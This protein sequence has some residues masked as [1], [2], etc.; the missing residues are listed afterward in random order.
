MTKE[1]IIKN[2]TEEADYFERLANGLYYKTEHNPKWV[3]FITKVNR[4]RDIVK[5]LENSVERKEAS[6]VYNKDGVDWGIPSW[7]CS[8]CKCKNDMIP[9]LVRQADGKA[10]VVTNPFMWAGSKFCPNCGAVMKGV[11]RAD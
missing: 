11:I 10:R 1:E 4:N 5:L 7:D 8:K 6:W 9:T 3:E 2:L